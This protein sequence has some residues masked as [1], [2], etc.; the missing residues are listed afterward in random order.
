MVS[1]RQCMCGSGRAFSACCSPIIRSTRLAATAEELMRSRFTANVLRDVRYILDSWYASTRPETLDPGSIPQW[2]RLQ[3]VDVVAGTASDEE[4]IVEFKATCLQA[5]RFSLLH[6]RSR[7]V[8]KNG[9]WYYLDGEII[10]H[11]TVSA[12]GVG[13][14]NPCPC[15]SGRKYKKCCQQ[16]IVRNKAS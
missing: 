7:F 15:G 3:I 12:R 16:T 11:A 5:D 10:R 13:R 6:E 14:N 1:N 4:G 9:Q 8:R 2:I